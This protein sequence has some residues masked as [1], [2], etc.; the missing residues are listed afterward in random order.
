[1]SFDGKKDDNCLTFLKSEGIILF[2]EMSVMQSSPRARQRREDEG[3][4]AEI[5]GGANPRR[6]PAPLSRSPYLASSGRRRWPRAA[7]ERR[8]ARRIFFSRF[9]RNT[10]KR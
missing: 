8:R 5:R 3:R 10:L 9:W 2:S 4:Q 6:W 7:G 1:M